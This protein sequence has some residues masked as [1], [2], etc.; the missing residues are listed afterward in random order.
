MICLIFPLTRVVILCAKL[1]RLWKTSSWNAYRTGWVKLSNHIQESQDQTLL[2]KTS[3]RVITS[4]SIGIGRSHIERH[5]LTNVNQIK[6]GAAPSL[7]FTPVPYSS[8]EGQVPFTKSLIWKVKGAPRLSIVSSLLITPYLR[9]RL[10]S[11]LFEPLCSL[12][13]GYAPIYPIKASPSFN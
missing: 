12:G 13:V 11:V 2:K 9:G 3:T 10:L 1:R 5:L 7:Q 6:K 4:F 8:L